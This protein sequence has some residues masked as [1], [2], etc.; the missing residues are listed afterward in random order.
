MLEIKKKKKWQFMNESLSSR[1]KSNLDYI[2]N[3]SLFN[4][5][6][7]PYLFIPLIYINIPEYYKKR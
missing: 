1:Y 4:N 7:E 6:N 2:K 5:S 3:N